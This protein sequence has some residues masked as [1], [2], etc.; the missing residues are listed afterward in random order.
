M[1]AGEKVQKPFRMNPFY[2]MPSIMDYL[3][4][5]ALFKGRVLFLE[6]NFS[7]H[8][9]GSKLRARRRESELVR[10]C[11]LLALASIYQ[12]TAYE[13]YTLIKSQNLFF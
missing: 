8:V 9:H 7:T 11:M 3:R 5:V 10:E 6:W 4:K 2:L 1:S 13:T 12:T